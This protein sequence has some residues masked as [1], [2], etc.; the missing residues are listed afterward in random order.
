[1]A[2]EA[3]AAL[4]PAGWF[5]PRRQL[6]EPLRGAVVPRAAP[7]RVV[8]E[9]DDGRLLV[10]RGHGEAHVPEHR[11]AETRGSLTNSGALDEDVLQPSRFAQQPSV[12]VGV[13]VCDWIA[14]RVLWRALAL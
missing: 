9:L 10:G 4:V 11:I 7:V 14:D 12:V 1:A 6:D 2:P 5:R 13:C 8:D 3:P